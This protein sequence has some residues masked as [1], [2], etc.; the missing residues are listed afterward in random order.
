[1]HANPGGGQTASTHMYERLHLIV[2]DLKEHKLPCS[3]RIEHLECYRSN[4][5][6]E[7]ATIIGLDNELMGACM[8]KPPPHD[9]AKSEWDGA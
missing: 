8:S 6:A 3:K 1:M 7:E 5:G 9:L 4:H 2:G